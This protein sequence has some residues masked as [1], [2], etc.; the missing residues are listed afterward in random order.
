MDRPGGR[1]KPGLG[2]VPVAGAIGGRYNARMS[3]AHMDICLTD[4]TEA[5]TARL[6]AAL[7]P[8]LRTGD[9]VALQ[10]DLGAGK[11]AFARYLIRALTG[12]QTDVPSPTFNLVLVYDC[13][14][15]VV[16]H[17]DLYRLD[18]ADEVFELG[19][20]DA[21][22]EGISLIEWP[23]RMDGSL[24]DTALMVDIRAGE[25]DSQRTISVRGGAVWAERLAE[26]KKELGLE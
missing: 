18:N 14:Q 7:A 5:D 6:A 9:V 2:I 4:A 1:C 13:P 20:E 22:A 26:V 25:R 21:F 19:I 24:P 15:A 12:E 17:F 10:G 3:H 8:G 16:W 11:T 23:D